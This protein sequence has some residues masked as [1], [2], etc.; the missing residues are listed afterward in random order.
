MVKPEL[1]STSTA[2]VPGSG[3]VKALITSGGSASMAAVIRLGPVLAGDEGAPAVAASVPPAPPS[4]VAADGVGPLVCGPAQAAPTVH[5]TSH[6]R[7]IWL[8][9]RN[10]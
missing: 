10:C 9:V 7:I 8:F 1:T 4:R 2:S 6:S 3:L 5:T